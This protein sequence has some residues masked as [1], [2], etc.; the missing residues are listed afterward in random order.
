M[1]EIDQDQHFDSDR[2]HLC[3]L[4]LSIPKR[5]ALTLL[6]MPLPYIAV[7]NSSNLSFNSAGTPDVSPYLDNAHWNTLFISSNLIGQ[8]FTTS[9]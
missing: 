3:H 5:A 4:T 7:V 9:H 6:N 2:Y 1:V 8:I